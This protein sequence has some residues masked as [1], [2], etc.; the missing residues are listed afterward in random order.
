MSGQ[1]SGYTDPAAVLKRTA[2]RAQVGEAQMR[3]GL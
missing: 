3:L 2:K 1:V